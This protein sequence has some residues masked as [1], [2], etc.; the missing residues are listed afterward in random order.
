[1][2]LVKKS[3][4]ALL[5]FAIRNSQYEFIEPTTEDIVEDI[6]KEYKVYVD[7]IIGSQNEHISIGVKVII[8]PENVSKSDSWGYRISVEGGALFDLKEEGLSDNE[9][10]NLIS[11]SAVSILIS[12]IRGYIA[13]LTSYA[14]LGKYILPTIDVPYLNNEKAKYWEDIQSQQASSKKEHMKQEKL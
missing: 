10:R 9:L 14:P 12:N 2:I 8:N 3:P 5:D 13:N 1:M 6:F 11:F 7:Y 4:L